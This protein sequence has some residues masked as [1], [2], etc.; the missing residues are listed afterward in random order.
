MIQWDVIVVDPLQQGVVNAVN[1]YCSSAHILG[2]LDV[3][4]CLGSN[5]STTNGQ[6]IQ[7]LGTITQR[8]ASS[9]TSIAAQQTPFHGILLSNWEAYFEPVVLSHLV[10]YIN[11]IGLDVWLEI[12]GDSNE[13]QYDGVDM[14]HVQGIVFQNGTIRTDGRHQDYF[15]M[16]KTRS[17]MRTLAGQKPAGGCSFAMWEVVDD[18]V[19]IPHAVMRRTLKWCNYNTAMAWIGP[20]SAL[21]DADIA[22]SRTVIKEPLSALVWL[23]DDVVARAHDHWRFNDTVGLSGVH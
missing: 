18:E 12:S 2:R 20:R 3:Q 16:S 22:A 9:F 23:R 14:S 6:I 11:H 19:T 4:G 13:S 10:E 7:A 8:L 15:Q 5:G 21:V 17:L 1:I